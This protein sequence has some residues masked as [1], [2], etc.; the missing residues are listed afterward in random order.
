M[1]VGVVGCNGKMGRLLIEALLSDEWQKQGLVL[2]GGSAQT[3]ESETLN[4]FMTENEEELF[5]RSDVII[6]F[7]LP[8]GTA[9]HAKLAKKHNTNLIVGTTGL[10]ENDFNDLKDAAKDVAVVYSSMMSPAFNLMQHF[11]EFVSY[12][13]GEDWDIELCDIQSRY[14]VNAP[15]DKMKALG[16]AA[17]NGRSKALSK[18]A[19]YNRCGHTGVREGGKIG[20]T[21]IRGGDTPGTYHAMFL[22]QGEYV[23]MKHTTTNYK[24]CAKGALLAAIWAKDKD[25]GFYS[26]RDVIGL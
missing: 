24:T 2:S 7:T 17:A 16:K 21:A 18:V 14:E 6:D 15:T 26:M 13:L 22:T 9:T 25:P 19:E 5:E 4:C 1:N 20:I 10:S 12:R 3:V 11:V 8:Q 23:E